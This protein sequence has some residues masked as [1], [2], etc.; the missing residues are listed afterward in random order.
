VEAHYLNGG[1]GSLVAETIA[2]NGLGCRLL[3]AGVASMPAGEA[4]S[5]EYLEDRYKLAAP[6]LAER[7]Q[8]ALSVA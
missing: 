1:L 2:E 5:Q 3:R 7:L 4:G 6:R 8:Q